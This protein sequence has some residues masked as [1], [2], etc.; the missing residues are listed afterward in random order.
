MKMT[1][2][3]VRMLVRLTYVG[4]IALAL[5]LGAAQLQASMG[6]SCDGPGELGPCP[7]VTDELCDCACEDEFGTFGK[8]DLKGCCGCAI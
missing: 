6:G 8:C 5:G 3:I 7:P 4:F 1:V 2:R